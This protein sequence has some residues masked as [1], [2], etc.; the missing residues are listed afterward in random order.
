MPVIEKDGVDCYVSDDVLQSKL[1]NG[2][3]LKDASE[4][5]QVKTTKKKIFKKN[6]KD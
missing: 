4:K 3:K 1:R 6:D 5:K 2:W